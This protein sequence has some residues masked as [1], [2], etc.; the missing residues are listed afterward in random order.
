MPDSSPPRI[1]LRRLILFLS[2]LSALAAL[3]STFH[4]GY[5]VQRQQLIDQTL[6][7]SYMYA[8]KLATSTNEFLNS[9]LQQLHVA[10][11][12]LANQMDNIPR[13]AEEAERLHTQ[14]DSFNSV[15]ITDTE[16]DVLAA[17]P[18]TLGI[19]GL[20]L[21]TPGVQESLKLRKPLISEPYLS[22][23]GNFLIFLSQ[24]IY[25]TEGKFLGTVGGSIYL[26]QD[27]ILHRLLGTHYYRD[28]SYLYVV[29]QHGTILYHPDTTRVGEPARKNA[30]IENLLQQRSGSG[31]V[32]NSK[33]IEMI[34]GYAVM[35]LTNW[36][37]VAQRPLSATLAPLDAL[38]QQML[39]RTVPFAILI[40]VLIWWCASKVSQ[41]LQFLAN[42]AGNM[43]DPRTGE[44]INRVKS[45][46]FEAHEL[47]RMMLFGVNLLNKKIIK[48]RED[49]ETDALTKLP[50]RRS[51][52]A[53]LEHSLQTR[54]AFSI[55]SV[56]I[57][58]FKR[59]NDT[60][61]H[62][63]GD[64][65]LQILAQEMMNASRQM[66]L[67][68]RVGGEEFLILLPHT[69]KALAAHVAERLRLRIAA[70]EFEK[71][72]HI[73]ISLGVASWPEDAADIGTVLKYADIML[74]Q[75]KHNGRNRVE[76]HGI[77]S[78][79]VTA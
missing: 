18:N 54:T 5:T 30:T 33:G 67:P 28:G 66:D 68:C 40:F 78:I 11:G 23:V 55:I 13:L 21:N 29:D 16:G 64:I 57:D 70:V 41:P 17:S 75:A 69:D 79:T 39:F 47:K 50:N 77:T 60:Y 19:V 46:Y 12:V 9:S 42:E 4:S 26:K 63:N 15:V 43:D 35:P 25:S 44:K 20:R 10:A 36:G 71:V 8:N 51:L 73:T 27:S 48:L 32:T 52:D 24:P 53:A 56:D 49:A 22:A 7:S 34:T 62:D 14:T 61:G 59:I 2:L 74:Y 31:V 72:G 45:W 37:I 65:V 6:E 76:V 38:M 3:I 58:H 1:N